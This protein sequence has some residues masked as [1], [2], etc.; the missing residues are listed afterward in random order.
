VRTT[1]ANVYAP[2]SVLP[3]SGGV[4]KATKFP[5]EVRTLS[6]TT[7]VLLETPAG[8]GKPRAVGVEYLDST[9]PP[10]ERLVQVRAKNVTL[11]AGW[12]SPLILQ[13]SGIGPAAVLQAAGIPVIVDQ[14]NVG[15]NFKNQ[16]GPV[17]MLSTTDPTILEALF[18][19]LLGAGVAFLPDPVV[20]PSYRKWQ[21]I[22][23]PFSF[24]PTEAAVS[25]GI[26]PFDPTAAVNYF[27]M[28]GFDV[29]P[30]SV[31]SIDVSNADPFSQPVWNTGIYTDGDLSDPLSDASSAVRMYKTMQAIALNMAAALP[32]S[33]IEVVFPSPAEFTSDETLFS[34]AQATGI[35][36]AHPC[37]TC[38]MDKDPAKG[39]VDGDLKVHG[40][41]NLYVVDA[42]IMPQITPGN[43][44]GTAI[45]IGNIAAKLRLRGTHREK[46]EKRH[47]HKC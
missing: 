37:C 27:C 33:G 45:M 18:P 9:K 13:H 22:I 14:P 4:G 11:S 17:L 44:C 32:T 34:L 47:E 10:G 25:L 5:L 42:Q 19:T 15:Q 31:G 6:A 16:Y 2:P 7:K 24:L 39:V 1:T 23:E 29:S 36:A 8:G 3:F 20:D 35:A 43:L 28:L 12:T 30:R 26:T 38:R 41:D 40:V 21:I 46:Q